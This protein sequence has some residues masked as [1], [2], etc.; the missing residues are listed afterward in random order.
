[1]SEDKPK[2]LA[3]T[4]G[5]EGDKPAKKAAPRKTADLL[6]RGNECAVLARSNKLQ[7]ALYRERL[8]VF[9]VALRNAK[10]DKWVNVGDDFL[11]TDIVRLIV[12]FLKNYASAQ[13]GLIA[14]MKE[15]QSVLKKRKV[16]FVFSDELYP[17]GGC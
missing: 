15:I 12:K 16:G 11:P 13:C 5:G 9:E 8:P 7:Y 3:L 14:E 4:L 6:A 2:Q 10:K 17:D 1:M